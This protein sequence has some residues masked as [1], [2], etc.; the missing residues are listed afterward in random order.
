MEREC[1]IVRSLLKDAVRNTGPISFS[2][3][4][5]ISGPPGSCRT[6]AWSFTSCIAKHRNGNLVSLD[7][8][9]LT[10]EDYKA[11]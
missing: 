11:V 1:S 5:G 7:L 8:A 10:V 9:T 4:T 3:A 2:L 6:W